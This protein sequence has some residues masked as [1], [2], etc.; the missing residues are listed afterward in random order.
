[1]RP[2]RHHL[3]TF[4]LRGCLTRLPLE[5]SQSADPRGNLSETYCANV[6]HIIL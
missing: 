3:V 2:A 1:M 5:T 6:M 4:G